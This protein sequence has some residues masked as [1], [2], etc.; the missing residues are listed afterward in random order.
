MPPDLTLTVVDQSPVRAGGDAAQALRETVALAQAAEAARYD[1]YWVTEHHNSGSL[2]GTAPE[3]LIGQIAA[4]TER[5]RVGSAGVMLTHYSA[6][7]VA[8]LFKILSALYPGRIDLGIGRAPGSD[9]QT[10][11]ALAYPRQPMDV[12]QFPAQV[13][14]ILSYLHDAVPEDHVFTGVRAQAGP[15]I[16]GLP[17]SG[18]LALA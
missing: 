8:E 15:L 1:R 7:K 14:D 6:L 11:V 2:A 13:A 5:I 12:Q 17:R 9:Q 10:A 18:C 16:E 4:R 3:L